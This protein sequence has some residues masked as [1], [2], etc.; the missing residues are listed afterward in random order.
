M[1]INEYIKTKDLSVITGKS[2]RQCER[3]MSKIRKVNS[4]KKGQ[5]IKISEVASFYGISETDV[6]KRLLNLKTT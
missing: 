1:C 5:L 4:K 6:R 2:L 3:D